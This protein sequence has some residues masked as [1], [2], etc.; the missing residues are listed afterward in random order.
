MIHENEVVMFI[1]GGLMFFFSLRFR[2]QIDTLPHP[3]LFLGSYHCFF[4]AWTFT[5]IE[6]FILY[7]IFN[8]LEHFCYALGAVTLAI[9]SY[10]I[11]I[12]NK[13]Q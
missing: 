13:Y 11:S 8:I 7:D 3:K 12:Q 1:L 9:W 10:R 2:D 5:I 6:G 4:A